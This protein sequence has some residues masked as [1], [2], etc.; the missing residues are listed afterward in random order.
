[1]QHDTMI[2]ERCT[3]LLLAD[4]EG[5]GARREHK[6]K[7][8]AGKCTFVLRPRAVCKQLQELKVGAVL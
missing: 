1:M 6:G 8:Y 2:V 5:A 4:E 3:A 7:W